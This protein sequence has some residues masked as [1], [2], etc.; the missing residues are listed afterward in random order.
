MRNFCMAKNADVVKAVQVVRVSVGQQK[1][2]QRRKAASKRLASKV[3][4]YVNQNA[5]SLS[6]KVIFQKGACSVAFVARV[7]GLANLAIAGDY[8]D[9]VACS[10]PQ[11]RKNHSLIISRGN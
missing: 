1:R 9:A 4:A 3:G 6:F 10:A 2:V 5:P 7:R 8:R 11:N